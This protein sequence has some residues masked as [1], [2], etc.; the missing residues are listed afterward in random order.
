LWIGVHRAVCPWSFRFAAIDTE[1][2]YW[3]TKCRTNVSKSWYIIISHAHLS[4]QCR[5]ILSVSDMPFSHAYVRRPPR[6]RKMRSSLVYDLASL[7]PPIRLPLKP[8]HSQQPPSLHSLSTTKPKASNNIPPIH[9]G[10]KTSLLTPQKWPQP[11]SPTMTA[12]SSPPPGTASRP[13]QR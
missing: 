8:K 13:S 7:H 12:S 5:H 2:M 9:Q 11:P 6:A 1:R 10:T 4:R 3:T